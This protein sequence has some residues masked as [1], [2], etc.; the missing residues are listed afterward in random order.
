M[1]KNFKRCR[2]NLELTQKELGEVL[3]VSESTI[4]GWENGYDSIPLTKLIKFCNT[5]NF[6]VDYVTG[7]ADKNVNF[8]EIPVPDKKRLG[9]NL[10]T[11]RK[12]LKLSQDKLAAECSATHTAIS[13]YELGKTLITSATLYSICKNHKISMDKFLSM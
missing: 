9:N 11:L 2:Q 5:Y 10:R 13:N 1:L 6:T 8:K 7:L 12:Q 4:G 3:G